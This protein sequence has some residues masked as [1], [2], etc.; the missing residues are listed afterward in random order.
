MDMK[1]SKTRIA[2]MGDIH[3][4]ESDHGKWADY[5]RMVSTQADILLLCGDLTDT[6]SVGEAKVLAQELRACAIPIIAVLGNHDFEKNHAEE[7]RSTLENDHIHILDGESVVIGD[8]GFAG[9]KGFGGGFDRFTLAMFGEKM[10]KEFVQETVNETLKLDRALVRLD[11]H[12]TD[13]KKIVLLHYSPVKSTVIGEPE[14]IFPFLG[15]SRLAEPIDT[16]QVTAVFHG[17][18]H[19]GM[20]EGATPKGVKVFNVSKPIL[21][22][23]G[24]PF[25]LFEI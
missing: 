8:I 15:S 19:V 1:D 10:L 24:I 21:D 16:R 9:T 25:Y 6:G 14:Q 13:L 17:H 23:A 20:M 12:H 5:F 2:A 3:M 18:A 4:R 11:S 7:I 22:K